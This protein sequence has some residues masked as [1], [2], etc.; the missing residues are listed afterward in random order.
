MAAFSGHKNNLV[1]YKDCQVFRMIKYHSKTIPEKNPGA[2][3]FGKDDI[4][5]NVFLFSM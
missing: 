4:L 2:L 3:S 1:F 5:K